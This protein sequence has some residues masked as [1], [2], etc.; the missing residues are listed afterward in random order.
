MP[1]AGMSVKAGQPLFSIRSGS[2][3]AR[4][5]SPIG[6]KVVKTNPYLKDDCEALEM[7]P[8]DSNWVCVIDADNLDSELPKLAIGKSAVTLYEKDIERFRKLMKDIAP[9]SIRDKA[10]YVGE[11]ADLSPEAWDR[12]AKEFFQR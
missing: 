4:F 6:G 10:P 11:L 9:V 12:A 3:I 2:R 8:Y 5:S 1:N 7:T